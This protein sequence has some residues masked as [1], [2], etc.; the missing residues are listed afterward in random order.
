[1]MLYVILHLH[2]VIFLHLSFF[3]LLF[4]SQAGQKEVFGLDLPPPPTQSD[5][6]ALKKNKSRPPPLKSTTGSV[7]K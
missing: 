3:F 1:M 4:S 5:T 2:V 6:P 7:D